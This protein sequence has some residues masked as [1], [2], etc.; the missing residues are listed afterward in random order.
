LKR[1]LI[2]ILVADMAGYS[3]L[4]ERDEEGVITRQKGHRKE[5]IDPEISQRDGILLKNTGDGL[6][7]EFNSVQDAIRCAMAI[8]LG[9]MEREGQ[10]DDDRRIQYRIGINLGDLVFDEDDFFGDGLNVAARLEGL[11]K[12]GGITVSDMVFQTLPEKYKDQLE[13]LGNQKV[14]NISRPIRVWQWLPDQPRKSET[15]SELALK[16]RVQYTTSKDGTQIAWA[17]IGRGNALVK[18]PNWLNHLDYEW[19]SPIWEPFYTSIAGHQDF[20][21][22]DQRGNGLSE[23]EVSDISEERMVEDMDAVIK[24][25]DVDR[26]A[27]FGISQ[28]GAFSIRYAVEYPEK[29]TCLI[30]FGAYLRGRMN[31]D[32]LDQ[33]QLC[34]VLGMMIEQGWG[35]TNPV[36]LHTFT[37]NF[38]PDAPAEVSAGFDE[39]QRVS[40]S[41]E[42]AR[43]VWDMNVNVDVVELARQ[44]KVPTLILH[45]VGDR[46]SP[47]EEGRLLAK[48][49]PNATFVELPGSNHVLV[50]NTTAYEQLLEEL[51]D[52]LKV[53]NI[54]ANEETPA[55][56]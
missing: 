36:F 55:R 33:R 42:N 9:M 39:L 5:L 13:D 54:E 56:G 10:A 38:M 31:R 3:R 22:F 51:E 40:T 48:T 43:K 15:K 27:L 14:K 25:A 12:P 34:E 50:P 44:V 6:I 19:R 29:V 47:L 32:S 16:Q 8:Q 52:F 20:I 18:A 41:P 11:A 45:C 35:S 1:R 49:I 21:R 7:V 26:F 4:M 46:V 24:A 28:G 53:N 30:L 2:V 37:S 23:W 17:R